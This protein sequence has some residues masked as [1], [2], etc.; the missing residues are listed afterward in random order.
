MQWVTRDTMRNC[1]T[2]RKLTG[3]GQWDDDYK[4]HLGCLYFMK[5]EIINAVDREVV[6][7]EL[8]DK[9]GYALMPGNCGLVHVNDITAL[10]KAEI[11][12]D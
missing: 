9:I 4:L 8:N 1:C 12:F 6:H 7:S 3:N 2:H 5:N 10:Y 11:W